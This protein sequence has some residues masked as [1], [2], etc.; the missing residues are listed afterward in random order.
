MEEHGFRKALYGI[1][2]EM[3]EDYDA[4]KKSPI[5]RLREELYHA[6]YV[7][8]KIG[9]GRQEVPVVFVDAGFKVFETDVSTLMI[10]NVGAR[11][12]SEDGSLYRVADLSD[13]PPIESYLIYGRVLEADSRPEFKVRII[14]V[15]ECPLLLSHES[16]ERVSD[17]ITKLVNERFS[18]PATRERA[19]RL[20]KRLINYIENILEEAYALK[21]E[22]LIVKKN[23]IKLLDGTL[24]RWFGLKQIKVFRFEGL[25]VLSEVLGVGKDV[26]V[27]KLEGVYG[28]IKTTKFTSVARARSIFKGHESASGLYSLVTDRSAEEAARLL[29]NALSL[30]SAS[31]EAVKEA[32][33][34]LSRT[35][36]PY[37]GLWVSRF[38]LTPDGINVMYLEVHS[39]E[40]PLRVDEAGRQVL[41]NGKV[42]AELGGKVSYVVNNIAAHRSL[43]PGLPPHGFMEVDRDVRVET[44]QALKIESEIVNAIRRL[45][46]ELGHPLEL[47]FSSAW[48]MRIGYKRGGAW[49][50]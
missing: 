25:D 9:L 17:N 43:I 8:D 46:R 15:D 12:R 24:V 31:L 50:S 2:R 33:A 28:L 32:V 19:I 23:A 49:W 48:K 34:V 13:Y 44:R 35:S 14:P 40:P 41:S 45:S 5:V 47:V 21:V 27:D 36:Q 37:T 30:G 29:N 10:V 20:F 39:K 18:P 16:S 26:L 22:N 42:A 6:Y 38:P 4:V 1:V 11:V 3:L 7:V